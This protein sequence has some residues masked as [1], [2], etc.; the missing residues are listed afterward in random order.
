MVVP[1]CRKNAHRHRLPSSRLVPAALSSLG[2]SHCHLHAQATTMN[3]YETDP[4]LI[5]STD[6][7][8]DLPAY[9]R[10][11]PKDED[12]R[13]DPKHFMS[14]SAES[15]EYWSSVLDLCVE[16]HIIVPGYEG[17]R[18]VFALGSV[19]VKSAHRDPDRDARRASRDHGM[20]DA[21]EVAAVRLVREKLPEVR[22]PIIYFSGEVSALISYSS[23][24]AAVKSSTKADTLALEAPRL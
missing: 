2:Q 12:F 9:G 1:W 4:T 14:T 22:V 16:S 15:L 8:A 13:P 19:I 21:N 18:D 7:Y 23:Y 24:L 5:P 10:Y 20:S 17:G 6:S 11:K 3:P